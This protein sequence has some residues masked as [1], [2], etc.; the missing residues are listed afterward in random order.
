MIELPFFLRLHQLCI[1]QDWK[2]FVEAID[3]I[4][5]LKDSLSH[6]GKQGK[7]TLLFIYE[8]QES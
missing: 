4:R 6:L 5:R 7:K 3:E 8:S 2:Q 1:I